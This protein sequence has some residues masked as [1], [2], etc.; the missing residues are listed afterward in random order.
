MQA[1]TR[2]VWRITTHRFV[3]QAFSGEGARLYGGLWN[4]VGQPVIYTAESRSLALLE[5]LVQDEPLRAHYVLIPAHLSENVS[6]E[7][8]GTTNLP[9]DWRT[10]AGREALQNL[11]GEWLRR[12]RSCVLAVPSAVMPAELNFLINS[13]HPDFKHISLGEPETLNTDMRLR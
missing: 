9:T 7:I 6:M 1:V 12:S 10:H 8:L 5:M 11:G 13:F 2:P 3:D 4:R